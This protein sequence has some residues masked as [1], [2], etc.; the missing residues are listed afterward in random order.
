MNATVCPVILIHFLKPMMVKS[1]LIK[2]NQHGE[3]GLNRRMG[4]EQT[5]EGKEEIGDLGAAG[6]LIGKCPESHRVENP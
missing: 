2:A 6:L 4:A 3:T 1:A 5:S